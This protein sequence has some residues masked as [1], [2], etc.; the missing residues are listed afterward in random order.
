M[1]SDKLQEFK[2]LLLRKR[3]E[4]LEERDRYRELLRNI[5]SE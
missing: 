2:E 1:T 3:K 5:N 4:T